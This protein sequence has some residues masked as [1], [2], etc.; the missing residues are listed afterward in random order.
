M[1]DLMSLLETLRRPSLLIRAARHGLDHYCR[2]RDL[3]RI[4]KSGAMP[5]PGQAVATL[6]SEE[7][8]YEEKRKTGD[9][10]YSVARHVEVLIALMAEA[11][12]MRTRR[13]QA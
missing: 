7:R 12:V 13:S 6:M 3:L 4:M 1:T 5:S 11:R 10:S 8:G 9:A 2:D